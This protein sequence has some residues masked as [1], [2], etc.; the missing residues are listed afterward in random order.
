MRTPVERM[1]LMDDPILR[2]T[3]RRRRKCKR[4]GGEHRRIGH[5]RRW[6]TVTGARLARLIAVF[7][8]GVV[9]EVNR[10]VAAMIVILARAHRRAD[11]VGVV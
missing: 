7:V 5:R 11:V 2:P 9:L 8:S 3:R 1:Q 6:M 4:D 10:P